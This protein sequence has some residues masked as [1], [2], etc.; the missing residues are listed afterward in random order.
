M[1]GK[2]LILLM[3]DG[4]NGKLQGNWKIQLLILKNTKLEYILS[5]I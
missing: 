4:L 5:L 1:K 3:I 2:V